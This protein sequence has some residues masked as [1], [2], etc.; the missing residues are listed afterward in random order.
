MLFDLNSVV[1]TNEVLHC[2]GVRGCG[3]RNPDINI[4]LLLGYSGHFVVRY[5]VIIELLTM[6]VIGFRK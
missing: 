3:L 5:L 4:V 2:G 6:D 1:A